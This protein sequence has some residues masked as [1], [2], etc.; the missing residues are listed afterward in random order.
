MKGR[1]IRIED[2]AASFQQS[3]IEI[4]VEKTI[5][6]AIEKKVKLIVL[7]GGVAANSGLRELMGEECSKHGLEL[8][9]P[10][11]KLCTDNAAMIGCVGYYNY[12]VN[13]NSNLFLNAKSNLKFENM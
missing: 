12:I 2:V 5:T 8:I 6:C 3:V 1:K 7:A 10:S 9:Y 11:R 4:L 13:K